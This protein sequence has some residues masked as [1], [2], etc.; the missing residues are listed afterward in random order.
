MHREKE[1]GNE[2]TALLSIV[3]EY[4][5]NKDDGATTRSIIRSYNTRYR[6]HLFSSLQ[7]TRVVRERWRMHVSR[8][9]RMAVTSEPFGEPAPW[10][11]VARRLLD[12]GHGRG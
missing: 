12:M 7:A 2:R 8:A 11:A 4:V 10:T 6:R 1:G 3:V 9:V 5:E